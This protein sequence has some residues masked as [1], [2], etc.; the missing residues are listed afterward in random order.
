MSAKLAIGAAA[1]LAAAGA[2]VDSFG[3][4]ALSLDELRQLAESK[5]AA[6]VAFGGPVRVTA[7]VDLFAEN[8]APYVMEE[9]LSESGRTYEVKV[10]TPD[11][12]TEDYMERSDETGRLIRWAV[13][14]SDGRMV[15]RD[16]AFR[17]RFPDQWERVRQAAARK[18][19]EKRDEHLAMALWGL[20]SEDERVA[21]LSSVDLSSYAD[22]RGIKAAQADL[23]RD[24]RESGNLLFWAVGS[25]DWYKR[26]AD[27]HAIRYL[28]GPIGSPA[29]S[30]SSL[31]R[32]IDFKSAMKGVPTVEADPAKLPLVADKRVGPTGRKVLAPWLGMSFEYWSNTP[33]G[34]RVAEFAPIFHALR[35]R[36]GRT[37]H[38]LSMPGASIPSAATP[39]G[40]RAREVLW[41]QLRADMDPAWSASLDPDPRML[42]EL[43]AATGRM[44]RGFANFSAAAGG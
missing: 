8:E 39:E 24:L 34:D 42:D 23:A 16:G 29:W 40:R 22:G 26:L 15:S 20:L 37:L 41:G 10:F 35:R 19:G 11:A 17:L 12:Y 9:R 43:I 25:D 32:F 38:H 5:R 3:S 31:Q 28:G 33:M 14:L 36:M 2:A 18:R 13:R 4:R 6:P 30:S 27:Q 7:Y 21:M 1:V 44:V